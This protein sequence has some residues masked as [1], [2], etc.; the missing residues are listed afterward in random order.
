MRKF[1]SNQ[2]KELILK[3]NNKE[4][5][6]WGEKAVSLLKTTRVDIHH[7]LEH[8]FNLA[9][10]DSRDE[11]HL[12]EALKFFS[13]GRAVTELITC[14]IDDNLSA[15]YYGNLGR[16]YH[17]L[18]QYD[19]AKALYSRAFH[20]TYKEELSTKFMNRGYVSYWIGQLLQETN[21]NKMAF[22]FYSNCIYYWKRHS[23]HRAQRVEEE[24]KILRK[25]IPDIDDILKLDY[26]IIENQCK[27]YNEKQLQLTFDHMQEEI[28][29]FKSDV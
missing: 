6:K 2:V 17:F 15:Q 14:Q 29:S 9:K 18:K 11:K 22:F 25:K 27:T 3:I 26:E 13:K 16:C 1:F 12:N 28:I 20:L 7:E 4:A 10:R 23:P 19:I 8:D 24:I 5:I 21:D